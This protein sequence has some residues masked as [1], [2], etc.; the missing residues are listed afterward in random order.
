MG[1]F[2]RLFLWVLNL[3]YGPRGASAVGALADDSMDDIVR[4]QYEDERKSR[5]TDSI[6]ESFKSASL[7]VQG[8]VDYGDIEWDS[9][10]KVVETAEQF[11]FSRGSATARIIAKA[12][13]TN[14]REIVALRRV[15][16]R[17]VQDCHLRDD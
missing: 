10:D 4:R 5:R 9:Y 8:V 1:S 6:V 2:V 3:F 11:V 17:H 12:A 15:I 14:R 16:R 13:F 7:P